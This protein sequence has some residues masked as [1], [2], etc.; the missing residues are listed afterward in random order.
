MQY[1]LA[2]FVQKRLDAA[3]KSPSHF[4]TDRIKMIRV[5]LTSLVMVCTRIA[6]KEDCG[7]V[8]A[9]FAQTQYHS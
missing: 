2:G 6:W 9:M 5:K 8:V 7:S 3:M 1:R 4:L